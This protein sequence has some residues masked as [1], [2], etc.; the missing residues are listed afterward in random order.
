MGET[1]DDEEKMV[2][3]VGAGDLK[4]QRAGR[5]LVGNCISHLI[6]ECYTDNVDYRGDTEGDAR[7]EHGS[8]GERTEHFEPSEVEPVW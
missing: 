3:V 2:G 5:I 6:L 7:E 1:A 8:L 4:L